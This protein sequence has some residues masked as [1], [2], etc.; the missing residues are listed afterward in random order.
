VDRDF[1]KGAKGYTNAGEKGG[2]LVLWGAGRR[3]RI[4]K[5]I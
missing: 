3:K 5:G 1:F 4:E 2:V